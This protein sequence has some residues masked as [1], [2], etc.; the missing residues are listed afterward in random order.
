MTSVQGFP[1]FNPCFTLK[2]WSHLSFWSVSSTIVKIIIIEATNCQWVDLNIFLRL[3][4]RIDIFTVSIWRFSIIVIYSK[5]SLRSPSTDIIAWIV[6]CLSS[7]KAFTKE[8]IFWIITN[9]LVFILKFYSSAH[10]NCTI[11]CAFSIMTPCS[12][13]TGVWIKHTCIV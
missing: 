11:G 3:R 5:L 8:L 2:I 12:K 9:Y 10:F 7:I 4:I 13:F 1:N 6:T